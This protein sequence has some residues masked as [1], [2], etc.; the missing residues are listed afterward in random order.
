MKHQLHCNYLRGGRELPPGTV[1]DDLTEEEI[2]SLGD[3]AEPVDGDGAPSDPDPAP[4]GGTGQAPQDRMGRIVRACADLSP[5]SPE[6]W[7]KDGRPTVEALEAAAKLP[8]VAAAER[9]AAWTAF[10]AAQGK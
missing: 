6:H 10:R 7:T 1:V 9:D 3:L 2:A 4:A 8:T 5:L